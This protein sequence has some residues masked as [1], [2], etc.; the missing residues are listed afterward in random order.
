MSSANKAK[1]TRF[2]SAITDHLSGR[3]MYARRLP[4]TGVNDVGDVEVRL[5][6]AVVVLE[7]KATKQI[8]LAQF[9]KEASVEA[10]NYAAKFKKAETYGA[11]VV[12]RR[13]KGTGQAYV[14]ME[15]DEF[16]DLL[17]RVDHGG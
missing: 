13:M 16:M 8:D 12:K 9:V 15:L 7:A 1:G 11:A 4:R 3:G 5:S 10:E 6:D 14:V 2:E 17:V